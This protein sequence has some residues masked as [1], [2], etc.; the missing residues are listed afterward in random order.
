MVCF[1]PYLRI[2]LQCAHSPRT[3]LQEAFFP[4]H[5]ELTGHCAPRSP[6]L[7]TGLNTPVCAAYL[8]EKLPFVLGKAEDCDAVLYFSSEISRHH[9]RID[10]TGDHVTI[11]DLGSA[12]H[13][14][15]NGGL[16]TP[17][18]PYPIKPGDQVS[19]SVFNFLVEELRL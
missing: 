4:M 11:T 14:R 7:L 19:F 17:N 10:H 12:N 5:E 18:A 9:A 6:L 1:P 8:V 13:T 3:C 2:I 16:L 15:L